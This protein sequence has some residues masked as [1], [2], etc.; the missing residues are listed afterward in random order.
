MMHEFDAFKYSYAD[1]RKRRTRLVLDAHGALFYENRRGR[2]RRIDEQDH[3]KSIGIVYG[4][5]TIT[6]DRVRTR[7]PERCF[8]VVRHH[9]T[10]DFELQDGTNVMAAIGGVL[11]RVEF[12][13]RG[14]LTTLKLAQRYANMRFV[15]ESRPPCDVPARAWYYEHVHDHYS[16][17]DSDSGGDSD[18]EAHSD[19]RPEHSCAICLDDVA[20]GRSSALPC[21]HAFHR[22]CIRKW[23]RDH[24][25]CPVC[26]GDVQR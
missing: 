13:Q 9:R 3:E 6:F 19:P 8:S 24:A 5:R 12:E 26:R 1:S 23:L 4:P 10:Y 18:G 7:F 22:R 15:R 21:G 16:E 20:G 25:T 2:L 17:G 14:T 11:R